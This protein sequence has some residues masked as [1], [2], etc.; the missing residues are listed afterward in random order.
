MTDIISGTLLQLLPYEL[1]LIVSSYLDDGRVPAPS[2]YSTGI[3]P[4]PTDVH[5]EHAFVPDTSSCYFIEPEID[6]FRFLYDSTVAADFFKNQTIVVHV[7]AAGISLCGRFVPISFIPD[8]EPIGHPIVDGFFKFVRNLEV[9]SS[10]RPMVDETVEEVLCMNMMSS[11][12]EWPLPMPLSEDV[13]LDLA[14]E[15]V[16]IRKNMCRLVSRLRRRSTPLTSLKIGVQW[17]EEQCTKDWADACHMAKVV[18]KEDWCFEYVWMDADFHDAEMLDDLHFYIGPL[19]RLRGVETVQI[20]E[21]I[22]SM[23][24]AQYYVNGHD[25]VRYNQRLVRRLEVPLPQRRA[26]NWNTLTRR[27]FRWENRVIDLITS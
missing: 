8:D 13:L 15:P 6:T 27:W 10:A 26:H 5:R 2:W 23:N 19:L 12:G 16:L 17:G 20:G 4:V 22:R 11:D 7:D 9:V 18:G 25:S 14:L 3:F 21:S 24:V 1:K